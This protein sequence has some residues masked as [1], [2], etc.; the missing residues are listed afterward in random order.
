M[1]VSTFSR[2]VMSSTGLVP[3]GRCSRRFTSPWRQRS[4]PEGGVGFTHTTTHKGGNLELS[5]NIEI[6]R[7]TWMFFIY[8]SIITLS[9]KVFL[10]VS[11]GVE[12]S[13]WLRPSLS[14]VGVSCPV[15]ESLHRCCVSSCL[16]TLSVAPIVSHPSRRRSATIESLQRAEQP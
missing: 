14:Q 10:V 5:H 4:S 8:L 3:F 1:T 11:P 6:L 16:Q 13:A 2:P 9:K 12:A 15:F 7:T